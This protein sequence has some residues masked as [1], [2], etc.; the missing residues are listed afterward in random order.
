MKKA[1][2]FLMILI[3]AFTMTFSFCD[4]AEAEPVH[5]KKIVSVVYDD[6]GSMVGDKWAYANYAQQAFCGMLNSEDQLYLTYMSYT[7]GSS[8]YTPGK[9]DLSSSGI[10]KSIENIKG[11]NNYGDK[12]PFNSVEVAFNKLKSVKDSNNNTQY[13]LVIITDGDFDECYGRSESV[14]KEFL[15]SKLS[16][17]TDITMPNGTKPQ[18]TFLAIGDG[19]VPPDTDETR[20]IYVYPAETA[21]EIVDAMA[22]MAD[23]VSGRTCLDAG[24][25]KKENENTITFSSPIPLFNIAVVEQKT[26]VIIE[27]ASYLSGESI[28]I[29]REAALSYPEYSDLVGRTYLV[30]DSKNIIKAEKYRIT[31]KESVDL[32]NLLILMEPALEVRMTVKVNGKE[33]SDWGELDKTSEYDNI[34]VKCEVYEVGSGKKVKTSS[35]PDG[36]QFDV[37][38]IEEGKV[39]KKI[40][41]EDMLL[42]EYVLKKKETV[43][44]ARV[45]IE[46]FNPI[47]S[48]LKFNPS[49][50]GSGSEFSIK[51]DFKGPQKSVSI[52]E[53]SSNEDMAVVFSVYKNGQLVTDPEDIKKMNPVITV[54]PEGNSGEITYSED[55]KILF[56]PKAASSSAETE[57]FEVKVQCAIGDGNVK[58]EEVYTVLIADYR[59]IPKNA[60]NPVRKTS[61]YDNKESVS[62]YITKNGT[63]LGKADVEKDIDIKLNEAYDKLKCNVEVSQDGNVIVT[64]YSEDEHKI[65]FWNWWFNWVYYFRL[66]GED[67]IVTLSH[68]WGSADAVIDV[69]GEALSYQIFNVYLP[70]AIDLTALGFLIAWIVLVIRKPRYRDSAKLYVGDIRYDKDMGVHIIRNFT[71]VRL[72][73]FNRIKK[74]NG[75]LKFKRDAD[76][77]SAGG[78]RI[79]ADHGGRIICAMPLPWFKGHVIPEDTNLAH[80]NS[81]AEILNYFTSHKKL[82]INEFITFDTVTGDHQRSMAPS[83]GVAPKYT[84]IP[85]ANNGIMNIDERR[86]IKSGKI[87]MYTN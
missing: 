30:G 71:A 37:S 5:I 3:I 69:T 21:D 13:W 56:T 79:R 77:V 15:N 26:D 25:I 87:F 18:I 1:F 74:G 28:P 17:F 27:S 83:A 39:S 10:Q 50:Y 73:K 46:G 60:A 81:P 44:N 35:L 53:V 40:T 62:F 63:K 8:S 64:P 57:K 85:D 68:P 80:L 72:N 70:L 22:S 16:G 43:I 67:V 23:R 51:S 36:T 45:S 54:S 55:G 7:L 66:P 12:T 32:D 76:V 59:V 42:S 82:E 2:S 48:T 86:V 14:K 61:F 65:N 6:S 24:K 58:D 41:D 38:V 11:H 19:I 84:V 75:R 29:S 33:V 20:G 47:G 4:A 49:A 78:I 9:V 52:R 34:T 31:F